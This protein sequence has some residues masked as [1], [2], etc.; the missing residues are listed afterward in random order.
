MKKPTAQELQAGKLALRPVRKASLGPLDVSQTSLGRAV[1]DTPHG[2]ADAVRGMRDGITQLRA[3][4]NDQ[5]GISGPAQTYARTSMNE[6]ARRT[7]QA[8]SGLEPAMQHAYAGKATRVVYDNWRAEAPQARTDAQATLQ[9]LITKSRQS[10]RT[11]VEVYD[12]AS[13]RSPASVER[14]KGEEGA[15]N[16]FAY[17]MNPIQGRAKD[18]SGASSRLSLNFDVAQGAQMVKRIIDVV[19]SQPAVVRQSKI[20]GPGTIGKRVD[21]AVVYLGMNKPSVDEA[22]R[23]DHALSSGVQPPARRAAP[24]GMEP[25]SAVSAYAEYMPNTSSSHG[26]N[27]GAFVEQV[28]QAQALGSTQSTS[29]LMAQ[30]LSTGGYHPAQPSRIMTPMQRLLTNEMAARRRAMGYED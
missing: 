7:H 24:P 17:R 6:W 26:N 19:Q 8:V 13:K 14:H 1:G 30:A 11:G 22:R 25:L 3:H 15:L 16:R 21:D 20:M 29:T 28:V 9:T 10:Q 18:P 23:V 12:Q 27:R 5:G 2:F 4:L